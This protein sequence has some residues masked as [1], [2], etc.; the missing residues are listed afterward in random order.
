MES[1][2]R[3]HRQTAGLHRTLED[4]I[5][6]SHL[7]W[8]TDLQKESLRKLAQQGKQKEVIQKQ[9]IEYYEATA[10]DLRE[11]ATMD[12]K[13][14]CQEHFANLFGA[15]KMEELKKMNESGATNDEMKE[16]ARQYIDEI[17]DPQ[18]K[19]E[20]K[21]YG[22]G[23][24]KLYGLGEKRKR[25]VREKRDEDSLD[26]LYETYLS[27]LNENQRKKLSALK[28]EGKPRNELHKEILKYYEEIDDLNKE[29]AS[30]K[31][32]EWCR[33]L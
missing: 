32:R 6:S 16:K 14:A 1:H 4:Y 10:G 27:W 23:C 20:A 28:E 18:K 5:Q 21:F 25:N 11:K 13:G 30:K 3:Y 7:S 26:Q 22:I 12:L 8:L 15:E 33:K 29:N 17:E 31:L 9:V 24:R 2:H 19:E